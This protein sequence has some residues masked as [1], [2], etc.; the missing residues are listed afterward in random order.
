MRLH[1]LKHLCLETFREWNEDD[2]LQWGAALAYYTAVAMAPLLVLL[3]AIG[4]LIFEEQTAREQL[5]ARMRGWVGPW[6]AD[7]ARSVLESDRASGVRASV[8]STA[9]VVFGAT[10]VFAH[11]QKALDRLW[12]V[13]PE[14]GGWKRM[15]RGRIMG[16]GLVLGIG[17]L[18]VLTLVARTVI[19]GLPAP[20]FAVEA[21]NLG[22]TFAAFTLLLGTIYKVLPDVLIGWRDVWTGAL[23]TTA[24]FVLGQVA[25]GLYLG[26]SAVG[27]TYGAAGSLVALLV[28]LYYSAVVFFFGAEFTQVWAR[29]RGRRIE[30]EPGARRVSRDL[31]RPDAQWSASA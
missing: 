16:F 21:L 26:R 24:L 10:G 23:V 6:G 20:G 11:L 18:L 9:L 22:T 29:K 27:S 31:S 4:A 2:A 30:P 13:E 7:V 19:S 15:V 14:K 28:W 5:L 17:A 12:E 3:L 8:T 1:D 25:I